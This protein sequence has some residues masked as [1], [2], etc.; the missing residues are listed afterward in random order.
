MGKK[1]GRKTVFS[2]VTMTISML[3]DN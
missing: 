2:F 3:E 1:T